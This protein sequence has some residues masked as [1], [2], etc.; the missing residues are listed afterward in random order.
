MNDCTRREFILNSIKTSGTLGSAIL[1][2]NILNASKLEFK[3]LSCGDMKIK[4][5]LLIPLI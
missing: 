2:P 5:A 3:D 4:V 1:F